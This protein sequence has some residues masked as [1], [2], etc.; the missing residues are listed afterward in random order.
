MIYLNKLLP[1]FA[2]PLGLI[3]FLII[4]G[5]LTKRTVYIVTA[6]LLLWLTSLP[7]VSNSLMGILERNYE[8]QTLDNLEEHDTVVVLSGMVRTI[9]NND[10]IHYEFTEAVDRILAGVRLVKSG[11]ANRMILTRGQLPWSLGDPEGEFLSEFANMNGIDAAKITL[12]RVVQNTDDEA[13]AIAELITSN[14]KLILIT[15][16]FHMPRARMVFENQNIFVTE[17]AVDFRNRWSKLDILDFL[18]QAKA[19]KDSS[20]FIREMIGRAYY[21]LKY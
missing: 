21:S 8:V 1:I 2:S 17:F 18:P 12:T 7:I 14:E 11:K 4:L 5:I 10:E 19:F 15:S 16:A 9:K 6:L 20:L 3:S 13:K